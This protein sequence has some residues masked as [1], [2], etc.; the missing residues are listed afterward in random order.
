MN[1]EHIRT[2]Y[3]PVSLAKTEVLVPT[4]QEPRRALLS[5]GDVAELLGV[6]VGTL[7]RW[8]YV[9]KGS[10]SFR[11]GRHVKYLAED[12]DRWLQ[13]QRGGPA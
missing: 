10:P 1:R 3:P 7:R 5:M 8:R 9:G 2:F 13:E 12:I 4:T 6:P 11:V